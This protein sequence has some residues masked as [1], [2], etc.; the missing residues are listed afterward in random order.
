MSSG[1]QMVRPRHFTGLEEHGCPSKRHKQVGD[2]E[3][4]SKKMTGKI[5]LSGTEPTVNNPDG[6]HSSVGHRTDGTNNPPH[7]EAAGKVPASSE[8]SW[9]TPSD[10]FE[11][12]LANCSIKDLRMTRIIFLLSRR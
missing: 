11:L 5:A 6:Q 12:E 7:E 2:R 10:P 3:R 9:R 4:T 8:E 1:T